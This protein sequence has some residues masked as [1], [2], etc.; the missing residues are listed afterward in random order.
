MNTEINQQTFDDMC[1]NI[2]IFYENLEL[3][4][5][6]NELGKI[7]DTVKKAD[8]VPI[9][10]DNIDSKYIRNVNE[11]L[12]KRKLCIANVSGRYHIYR[13]N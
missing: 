13:S 5:I 6:S 3:N 1:Q 4:I 8:S 11:I 2:H 7:L 9:W 10:L 12:C